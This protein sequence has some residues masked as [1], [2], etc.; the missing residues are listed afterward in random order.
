MCFLIFVPRNMAGIY[1]HIPFCKGKCIYCDFY[2][3][4]RLSLAEQYVERVL[5]EAQSRRAEL[6]GE[7]IR[8]L[9]VG[10]GTPSV[11][12][13]SQM[14]RLLGGLGEVF[15]LSQIEELTVEANPDDITAEFVSGLVA[16]GVNRLSMGVQSFVDAELRLLR[17]RHDANDAVKAV[18]ICRENGIQNVSIDLIYGIPGQTMESWRESIAKALS[19]GVEHIS[20]YSLTYESGTALDVMVKDGRL[21]PLPDET[22]IAMMNELVNQLKAAGYEHYEISNFA[23]PGYRSR[24]NSSYWDRTPYL[25][26]GAAAHSLLPGGVRRWNEADIRKYLQSQGDVP[27][28]IETLETRDCYNEDVMLGMR[29]REGVSVQAIQENYGERYRLNFERQAEQ[30]LQSGLMAVDAGR[31]HLTERGVAVSDMVI[32]EFFEV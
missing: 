24:H 28:G 4:G 8:T 29:T 19:M 1:V 20:A 31:Y 12:T 9:Y 13:V 14:S 16:L 23:K 17:R 10:G 3:V 22:C 11:L 25:G 32:R 7:P 15:E 5:A 2:S 18:G 6:A 26:L 30:F 21:K 27:H